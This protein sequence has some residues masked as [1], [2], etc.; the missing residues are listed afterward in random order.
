MPDSRQSQ[1]LVVFTVSRPTVKPTQTPIPGT[2]SFFPQGL[3]DRSVKMISHLQLAPR[4]K[5]GI[6]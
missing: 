6:Y 4:Q 2:G 3:N 5:T 1:I